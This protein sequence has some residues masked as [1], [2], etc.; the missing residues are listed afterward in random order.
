MT[1]HGLKSRMDFDH[2]IFIFFSL[3]R[4]PVPGLKHQEFELISA[5]GSVLIL[6][7]PPSGMTGGL[8]VEEI[9]ALKLPVL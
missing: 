2:L 8:S 9:S 6:D 1:L 5:S 3:V 7:R 4:V